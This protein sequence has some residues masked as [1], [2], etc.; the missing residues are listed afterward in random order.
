MEKVARAKAK[1]RKAK[2][3]TKENGAYRGDKSNDK[4]RLYHQYG[5]WGNECPNYQCQAG[6]QANAN[7][8]DAASTT[9]PSNNN[10]RQTSSAS[11]MVSLSSGASSAPKLGNCMI[12]RPSAKVFGRVFGAQGRL[13]LHQ[14][15]KPFPSSRKLLTIRA[16]GPSKCKTKMLQSVYQ[17]H[18]VTTPVVGEA[19][20][21]LKTSILCLLCS[22][23]VIW[24]I[25]WHLLCF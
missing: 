25:P 6:E 9:V 14:T 17:F 19:R 18:Q 4:C 2:A 5:H 15:P 13:S 11:T 8:R 3:R 22:Q 16:A 20:P 7:Q 10:G 21:V 24:E 23:L 1:E 12:V